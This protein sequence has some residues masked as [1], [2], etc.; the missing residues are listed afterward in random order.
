MQAATQQLDLL[1]AA[2]VARKTDPDTSKQ[3]GAEIT[4]SGKRAHQ[5]HHVLNMV[6]RNP[7][8]TAQELAAIDTDPNFDRYVYGRRLPELADRMPPLV[9]RAAKRNC[10]VTGKTVTT[11]TARQ[12][13]SR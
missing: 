10:T 11:W 12:S 7:G 5:Q 4:A 6:K 13:V 2:P 3:A 9:S 1:S 8:R